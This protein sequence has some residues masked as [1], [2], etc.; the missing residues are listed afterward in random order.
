MRA[1][2]FELFSGLT[3]LDR[4][5][6][7]WTRLAAACPDL[8]YVQLWGWHRA[9]QENLSRNPGNAL[10]GVFYDPAEPV[11][12]FPLQRDVTTVAG[13]SLQALALPRHE[14][15]SYADVLVRPE[16]R[17]HALLAALERELV[18]RDEAH[19]VLV[20]GPAL[21][22]STAS[23]LLAADTRGLRF[24]Q[25]CDQSDALRTLPYAEILQGLSKNFRGNLRKARNRLDKHGADVRVMAASTPTTLPQAFA[26]FLGLEAS[27]WKGP[28][29]TGTAIVLDPALRGFYT[30]LVERLGPTG[31]LTIQVLML[32]VKPIAAQFAITSG[33]RCYL[34]KIAYDEAQAALAPGNLLLERLL[35]K[36]EGHPHIQY[37]DLVSGAAWH[38]SWKPVVREV[39]RQLLF[40]RTTRGLLAWGLLRG[41]GPLRRLHRR[42]SDGLPQAVRQDS[43]P[44]GFVPRNEAKGPTR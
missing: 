22:D 14:H 37:V 41:K 6:G 26:H 31:A 43:R 27:G 4:L 30:Q 28:A 16:Y 11:A 13:I 25:P 10:F 35:Q 32:G 42:V 44:H 33:Q 3:G 12:I 24:T 29:G 18:M 7:D 34:L 1:L 36:Y 19:D 9:F 23:A 5:E 39:R 38:S 2:R 8:G 20:L 40:R 17:G 15:M 21:A